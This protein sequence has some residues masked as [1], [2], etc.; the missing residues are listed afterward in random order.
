MHLALAQS[1]ISM[2]TTHDYNTKLQSTIEFRFNRVEALLLWH[3]GTLTFRFRSSRRRQTALKYW[4]APRLRI[5]VVGYWKSRKNFE[6]LLFSWIFQVAQWWRSM[7][8]IHKFK[9]FALRIGFFFIRLC[10]EVV[11]KRNQDDYYVHWISVYC[12]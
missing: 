12:S 5:K 11:S 4:P 7:R 3:V 2:R 8:R 10:Y 1:N 6:I 9:C